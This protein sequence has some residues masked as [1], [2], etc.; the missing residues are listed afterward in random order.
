MV[1]DNT[2]NAITLTNWNEDSVDID[3]KKLA[4]P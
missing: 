2:S 3:V 1:W 4:I